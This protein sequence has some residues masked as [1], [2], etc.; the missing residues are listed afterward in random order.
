MRTK[1]GS[2]VVSGSGKLGGHVFSNGFGGSSLRNNPIQKRSNTYLQTLVRQRVLTI[3]RE[4]ASLSDAQ[5]MAYANLT[6]SNESAFDAYRRIVFNDIG[7]SFSLSYMDASQSIVYGIKHIGNGI[8]LAGSF[9]GGRL[10]RSDNFGSSFINLGQLY[11]QTQLSWFL[12]MP[13]KSIIC[14]T[15]PNG[16]VLRSTDFGL[17]FS[18]LGS[19][20]AATRYNAAGYSPTGTIL[21]SSS[22]L[23]LLVRSIDMGSTFSSV[24]IPFSQSQLRFI[25]CS[26]SGRWFAGG[27]TTGILIY[28]DD[29]GI[30]WVDIG[31]VVSSYI[32][33]HMSQDQRGFL[34]LV[35]SSG[36][37]SRIAIS[38]D[39]GLT[40][41]LS[42]IINAGITFCCFLSK[43]RLIAL[44]SNNSNVYIS[45]DSGLNFSTV[46]SGTGFISCNQ[47]DL[48]GSSILLVGSLSQG[49]IT[50]S[51]I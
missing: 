9:N 11:S 41:S 43:T 37:L 34:T 24:A 50:K 40:W 10:L 42:G 39:N 49:R 44:P 35:L 12:P 38:G 21:A 13:D 5:R 30:S 14:L 17:S 29:N 20:T 2:I 1:F 31:I 22:T 48:I 28:S 32:P 36:A 27:G 25:F 18:N 23:S 16:R 33:I 46:L 51:V 6:I 4:W 8:V 15:S 19:P 3:S 26:S 45:N 7:S 47:A